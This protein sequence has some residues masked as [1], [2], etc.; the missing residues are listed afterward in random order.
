MTI[1]G[2][3]VKFDCL[4]ERLKISKQP[5]CPLENAHKDAH[6][7]WNYPSLSGYDK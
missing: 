6:L 7:A 1:Q 3:D 5:E 2:V 4:M